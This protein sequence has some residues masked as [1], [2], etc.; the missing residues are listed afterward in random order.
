[1]PPL[2]KSKDNFWGY[3]S[4]FHP[5][6][7]T[8][9]RCPVDYCKSPKPDSDIYNAC[10]GKRTGMMC[11]TCSRGYTEILLSTHCKLAK[12]CKRGWFWI[13]FLALVCLTAFL[14]IFKPPVITF[15]AKQVLWF[16]KKL[17]CRR[18][19]NHQYG[20]VIQVFSSEEVRH[21][22]S[23]YSHF[24]E[25]IFYF[26]QISQLFLSPSSSEGYSKTKVIPFLLGFFNFQFSISENTCLKD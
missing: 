7:L 16:N 10:K 1:V 11:G 21:A 18:S 2:Y 3:K 14:L 8:F 13:A 24:V 5:P 25:I 17:S 9:T 15:L 20:N 6:T 12:D 22:N 23:Q 26:Y 19:A 4:G